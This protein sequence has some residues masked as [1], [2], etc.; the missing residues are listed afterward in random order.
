MYI[1]CFISPLTFWLQLRAFFGCTAVIMQFY[2]LQY[3]EIGD[4]T[5]I[6]KIKQK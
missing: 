4:A 1:V 6:K 5:V 2:A 3:I